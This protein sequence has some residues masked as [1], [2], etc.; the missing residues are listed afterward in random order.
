MKPKLSIVPASKTLA[1]SLAVLRSSGFV[2][3]HRKGGPCHIEAE[4]GRFII[5]ADN[6][7]MALGLL[8]LLECRGEKWAAT[9]EEV[10]AFRALARESH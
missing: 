10:R 9:D 7:L 3:T 5:R 1:P 6:P 2:V 8:K 4:D